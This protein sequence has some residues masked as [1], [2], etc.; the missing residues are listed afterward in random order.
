M[1]PV[2][3]EVVVAEVQRAHGLEGALVVRLQT[4]YPAETFVAERRFGVTEA[5]PLL[6]RE[7]TLAAAQPHGSG[8]ML[9]FEE[10]K[11]RTLAERYRGA[12]LT[13][14]REE[15]VAPE[16]SEFFLHD[17]VGLEVELPSGEVAGTIRDVYETAA[18]PILGVGTEDGERLV[19]FDRAIVTEVDLEGGVVRVDPPE[20][21][22]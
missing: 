17:L 19:P 20:G 21:L 13:L 9:H 18:R 10:L 16:E 8:W 22:L 4:D 12:R 11:D 2:Q 7:L 5:G 6:A 3:E 1:E 15:L 14:P